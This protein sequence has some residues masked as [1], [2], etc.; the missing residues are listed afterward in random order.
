[1]KNRFAYIW[2]LLAMVIS[3]EAIADGK[4]YIKEEV[5]PDIPYQR[6]LI[7]FEDGIETI[8]LQS[9]YEL[10]MQNDAPQMG[11]VVP[12]PIPPE[13][14][15]IDA[16]Q[17]GMMFRS[18]AEMTTPDNPLSF[19]VSIFLR[20]LFLAI[21]LISSLVIL[22][23]LISLVIPYPRWIKNHRGRTLRF[24]VYGVFFGFLFGF[25]PFLMFSGVEDK[26][27]EVLH[28]QTV[29]IHNV[30]VIKSDNSQELISW[31]KERN[32]SF[33][34]ED[35][36]A[37]DSY[38]DKG[39][40][41]VVS[42]IDPPAEKRDYE[43]VSEGLAAPLILRFPH[44]DPIYP[45]ELTAT[46]GHDTEILIYLASQHKRECGERL[47]H[48][49]TIEGDVS[50]LLKHSFKEIVPKLFFKEEDLGFKYLTK[51]TKTLTPLAMREDILFVR[52]D[53][54]KS[55]TVK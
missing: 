40:C 25:F 6:A 7:L 32:F 47:I 49:H 38:I 45:V 1:M 5:P 43:I 10:K 46:G 28:Q 29:G 21:M 51:F 37:F 36:N 9:K 17:A 19:V 55:L 53:G 2:F 52:S 30:N 26:G 35:K 39:W 20:F 24:A 54:Q 44:K 8:I 3:S 33:T 48:R 4:M 50:S 14:A 16:D 18:L 11:W 34:G 42:E 15:S 23:V 13:I 41:F 27:V 12:L 31:L 22:L